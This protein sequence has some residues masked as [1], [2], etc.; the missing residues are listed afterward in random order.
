LELSEE[1]GITEVA[2][3]HDLSLTAPWGRLSLFRWVAAEGFIRPIASRTLACM[4]E[5][6][7]KRSHLSPVGPQEGPDEGDREGVP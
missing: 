3:Y 6:T 1:A 2:I 4:K 7:E 5:V